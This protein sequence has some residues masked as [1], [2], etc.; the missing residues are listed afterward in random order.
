MNRPYP[1]RSRS[2]WVFLTISGLAA[3]ALL[4]FSTPAPARAGGFTED[5]HSLDRTRWRAVNLVGD[6]RLPGLA[7][8]AQDG[9]LRVAGTTS[10]EGVNI[11]GV[12]TVQAF[13]A[14]PDRPFTVEVTRAFHGGRATQAELGVM[15]WR[16]LDQFVYLRE[17]LESLFKDW[18]HYQAWQVVVADG[19]RPS[20]RLRFTDVSDED[21]FLAAH[22]QPLFDC[23]IHRVPRRTRLVHD[24]KQVSVFLDGEKRLSVDVSWSGPF[25]VCLLGGA[26]RS[27][28]RTE[29]AFADLKISGEPERAA[30]TMPI[31][32]LWDTAEPSYW[33]GD[34]A[35]RPGAVEK[36]RAGRDRNKVA[37][38]VR[39]GWPRATIKQFI[40]WSVEHGLNCVAIDI[41]WRD[42]EREPG[43]FDFSRSDGI[44]N[45]A[46]NRG[47]FVQ[48][49]PWWIRRSYPDW[50]S[51][52]LEQVA[53]GPG[54]H[55]RLQELT[56]AHDGLNDRLARF[57][58]AVAA[59]YRGYPVTCYTPVGATAAELE[60]SYADYRDGSRWAR[61]QFQ[62]WLQRRYDSLDAV[63]TAWGTSYTSW[64]SVSMPA[65]LAPLPGKPDTRRQVLDWFLY[66]EWALGQLVDRLARSMKAADPDAV[67]AIQMGR[68]LDGPMCPKRGT[69]GAFAWARSADMLVADPQPRDGDIMGYIVDLVRTGGKRAGMELDAPARFELPMDSYLSNTLE[70]WRHGGEWAS[71]ANWA[72]NELKQPEILKVASATAQAVGPQQPV[73]PPS[74]AMFV[75]KW[76][77]YCYHDGQRWK[78]YRDAY[79]DLTAGGKRVVDVLTD[80]ILLAHPDRLA[81]YE[82]IDIPYGDCLDRRVMRLLD[83]HKGGLMV[84]R[85]GSYGKNLIELSPP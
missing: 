65:D 51:P 12:R 30:E 58:G 26:H 66:R 75:S 67:L 5:F 2:R 74:V 60:Y 43:R 17:P 35:L 84:R 80:D 13:S 44:V 79:R 18:N 14:A 72:P 49:K 39:S 48:L 42:V 16:S 70:C 85:P 1:A 20:A 33:N 28:V 63:N 54:T 41:P 53:I 52:E 21:A 64:A 81:H 61:S 7:V 22:P 19:Q 47:L 55:P 45:Y 73:N 9:L 23:R 29:A 34:A 11:G 36:V 4:F 24:G 50:V 78:E 6:R 76:D 71:W 68:I 15:L 69:I 10:A 25:V 38:V 31:D 32:A 3:H 37:M 40:D 77:L 59:H 83:G 56:F 82:R 62:A 27:G 46:V 8:S 57:V